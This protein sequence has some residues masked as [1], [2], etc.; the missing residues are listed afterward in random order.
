MRCGGFLA[1]TGAEIEGHYKKKNENP[2]DNK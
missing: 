2:Q 1:H